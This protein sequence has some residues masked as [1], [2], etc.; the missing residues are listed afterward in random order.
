MYDEFICKT[1]PLLLSGNASYIKEHNK[2]EFAK[3]ANY[4]ESQGNEKLAEE[5]REQIR[6]YY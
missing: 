4:Y 6:K 1:I 2:R 3:C 5:Y